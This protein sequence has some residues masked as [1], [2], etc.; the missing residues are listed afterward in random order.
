M[1]SFGT[2]TPNALLAEIKKAIDEKKITTWSY[3]KSGDFTHTPDQWRAKAWLRPNVVAGSELRFG[4][5]RP[6]SASV[7]NEVYAVYHGRFIEMMLAH[8]DTTFGSGA[9][10][11]LPTAVD[12]IRAA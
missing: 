3:D 12:N 1:L 4:I 2:T 10:S 11:A 5:I 8:F 7:G 9:A 6:Q